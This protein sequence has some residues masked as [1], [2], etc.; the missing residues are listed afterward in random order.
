MQEPVKLYAR[1]AFADFGIELH[2]VATDRDNHTFAV[3]LPIMMEARKAGLVI[4]PVPPTM[5]IDDNVA[6]NLMD[7]L[8]QCGIRP[9]R[10]KDADGVIEAMRRHLDDM[11]AL[12]F[13][14]LP[15][16]LPR[17]FFKSKPQP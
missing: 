4:G 9:T 8:W 1:R 16:D 10:V 6:R 3:G 15:R 11:R 14:D 7:E 17:E 5:V 2:A 12:V 13:G